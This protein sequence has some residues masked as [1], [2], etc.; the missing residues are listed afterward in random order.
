MSLCGSLSRS[1]DLNYCTTSTGGS[2]SAAILHLGELVEDYDFGGEPLAVQFKNMATGRVTVIE[3]NDQAFPS[4]EVIQ[5]GDLSPGQVYEVTL[6]GPS[7]TVGVTA[8]PFFPYVYDSTA[9]GL[10]PSDTQVDGL[11]IRFVKMFDGNGGLISAT[12]QWASLPS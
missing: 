8:L 2:Y 4:I 7:E 3:P 1:V 12:E 11:F 10:V 6:T 9:S 5:P